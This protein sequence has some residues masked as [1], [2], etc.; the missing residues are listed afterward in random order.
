VYFSAFRNRWMSV[1]GLDQVQLGA[2]DEV[3]DPPPTLCSSISASRWMAS[4]LGR[5]GGFGRQV[6]QPPQPDVA[7]GAVE[8]GPVRHLELAEHLQ[9][10]EQRVEHRPRPQREV[11]LLVVE[12]GRLVLG[13]LDQLVPLD[14]LHDR[15]RV[16][17]ALDLRDLA[18]D[19]LGQP[20]AVGDVRPG[21]QG[22]FPAHDLDRPRV[23]AD[24]PHRDL[25]PGEFDGGPGAGG[26]GG[27]EDVERRVGQLLG[28]AADGGGPGAEQQG[29]DAARDGPAG[30]PL[31]PVPAELLDL[32][33]RVD[34]VHALAHEVGH[35]VDDV[36]DQRELVV[37]LHAG[38]LGLLVVGRDGLA[39]P[40]VVVV[41]AVELVADADPGRDVPVGV[42]G[43]D[44]P[45]D[46]VVDLAVHLAGPGGPLG[47]RLRRHHDRL[48]CG[49]RLMGMRWDYGRP[50][51]G[52][53]PFRVTAAPYRP[54]RPPMCS[55]HHRGPE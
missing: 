8:R 18:G 2:P 26:G 49:H 22:E 47:D 35:H 44:G 46:G 17:G 51:L 4:S 23:Q 21:E 41:A 5:I 27:A 48:F 13:Q 45:V 53:T 24:V 50:L 12:D 43:P 54:A 6:P 32:G 31:E 16:G 20:Q 15:P 40:E 9:V 38:V 10:V 7:D 36:A 33:G 14:G 55:V 3:H 34:D 29:G 28:D 30:D 42:G 37:R 1:D 25:P 11:V 52:G 39:G 19:V